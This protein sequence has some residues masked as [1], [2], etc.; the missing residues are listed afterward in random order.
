MELN[1]IKPGEGSQTYQAPRGSRHWLR[2]QTAGR[3]HKGSKNRVLLA[4]T[5][6]GL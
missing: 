3:G 5:T 2:Q 4:T 1:T 6:S